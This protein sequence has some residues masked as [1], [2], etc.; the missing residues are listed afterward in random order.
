M[1]AAKGVF[2]VA[3]GAII[4]LSVAQV[5]VPDY[6]FDVNGAFESASASTTEFNTGGII[7]CNGHSITVPRNLQVTYPAA[8]IGFKDF[9]A[10]S[11]RYT[12]YNCE[13]AGNVVNG[14]YIAARVSIAQPL[15]NGTSGYVD[16]VS[17]DGS[18]KLKSGVTIRINDPRAIYSVGYT[19]QPF[20]TA[21]DVNPSITSFSGFPMCVPRNA[22][23]PS[24][25]LSNRPDV[26]GSK[27]G[28]FHAP[29]PLVMAPIVTGD[30]VEYSGIQV[31]GEIIVYNL[32]VSNV[33]ITTTGVP[34]YIR[35][36]D[37]NVGVWAA[38]TANQEIAQTRFVGYTSDSSANVN[39]IKIYAIEYDPC[40]GECVDREIAAVNVPNTSARNKFE[41]LITA[42]QNDQ[43]AREYRIVAGQYVMP[44]SERIQPEDNVPG[45]PPAPHDFRR[46]SFLT[47]GLGRDSIGQLWGPLDPFPQT[48]ATLFDNSKC[49]PVTGNGTGTGTGKAP[50]A[51][52]YKDVVTMTAYSWVNSEGG[53]LSVD[54]QSNSTDDNAVSMK[55]SYTNKDGTTSQSM[56][57][58]GN[59]LWKFWAI[60]VKQPS[61]SSVICKSGIG[62]Y[63]PR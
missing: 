29:D 33:Q 51:P 23:D 1:F 19:S 17:F 12:G 25:P 46:Y 30:F 4:S 41:Y 43:Y 60:K 55:I 44:V 50:V 47:K 27:Q 45:R 42:P 11:S 9:V 36:E 63:A 62:D 40:T 26:A 7:K 13:V 5:Q 35:M 53:T 6:P 22:T 57:P 21:D 2:Y 28:T 54:C 32:I 52:K 39:P 56:R 34:T 24:C 3:L 14:V 59:G 20:F 8:F 15:L 10:S 61:V 31:G 16:K 38:D 37:V 18:I 48:G 49:A 58:V